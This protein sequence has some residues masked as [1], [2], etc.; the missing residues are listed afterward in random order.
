M[1]HRHPVGKQVQQHVPRVAKAARDIGPVF[2]GQ[3]TVGPTQVNAVLIAHSLDAHVNDRYV[4]A[5]V[6]HPASLV[7]LAGTSDIPT[8]HPDR[9]AV[10]I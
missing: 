7:M 4:R 2:Y 8:S 10:R 5:W 9:L 3:L 1:L 6:C